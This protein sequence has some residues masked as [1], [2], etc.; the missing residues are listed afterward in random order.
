[1]GWFPQS[2]PPISEW[3]LRELARQEN[4]RLHD[5]HRFEQQRSA[6]KRIKTEWDI[7]ASKFVG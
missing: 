4:A 6:A 5:L 7:V 3:A 1:M 2:V